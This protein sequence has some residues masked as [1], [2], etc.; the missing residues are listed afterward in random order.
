VRGRGNADPSLRSPALRAVRLLGVAVL[1]SSALWPLLP[2]FT[3]YL[4]ASAPLER[5][6]SLWFDLHCQRDPARTLSLFGVPLSVCA[7]C[8]GIYFGLGAG[9]LVR[10][11]RLTPGALRLW[12]LVSAASMLLDVALEARGLHGPWAS[13]RVLTGVL[14]SYPVGAGLANAALGTPAEAAA[15]S[16]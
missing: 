11:P 16:P 4:P 8:S 12:V 3:K 10:R 1:A 6:A 5:A 2:L 9:A 13:L 15:Q 7:R 14:L